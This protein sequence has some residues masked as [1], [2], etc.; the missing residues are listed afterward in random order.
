VLGFG[1]IEAQ[2]FTDIQYKHFDEYINKVII[3]QTV[4]VDQ[5]QY[6]YEQK[7]E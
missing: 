7:G 2:D 1:L 6:Q 3:P 5:K 4:L